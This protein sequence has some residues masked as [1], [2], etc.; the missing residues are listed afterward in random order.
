MNVQQTSSQPTPTTQSSQ[1]NSTQGSP[2]QQNQG[3]SGGDGTSQAELG[4]RFMTL[5]T[6]QLTN[7]DPTEPMDSSELT[8]QLAQ[9]AQLEQAEAANKQLAN[10]AAIVANVGN[11]TSM[12]I[13]G[14]N[15]R[16]AVDEFDWDA[17]K[18]GTVNGSILTDGENLDRDYKVVVKDEDGND[19]KTI[20]AKLENGEL[21]YEWD[22]TDEDGNKVNSG[23]YKFEVGYEDENGKY[24]KDEEAAATVTGKISSMEF[25]PYSK[26]GLDNGMSVKDAMILKILDKDSGATT[27]DIDKPET[28]PTPDDDKEAVLPKN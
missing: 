27:P 10:L 23:E 25:W 14:S 21:V 24:I 20:D 7:Q 18:G 5:L 11:I 22:G 17:S 4:S 9:L 16:I 15:A 8:A 26:T 2:S 19:V 6:A 3:Q 13:V 12:G 28:L 1:T